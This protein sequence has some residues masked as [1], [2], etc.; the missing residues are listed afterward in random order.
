MIMKQIS[1]QL[2]SITKWKYYLSLIV[3]IL[4]SS[5]GN[6]FAQTSHDITYNLIFHDLY[7]NNLSERGIEII[8]QIEL[9]DWWSVRIITSMSSGKKVGVIVIGELHAAVVLPYELNDLLASLNTM[10][11]LVEE[12]KPKKELKNEAYLY[13]TKYTRTPF[14]VISSKAGRWK[15]HGP[16]E[17]IDSRLLGS[18]YSKLERAKKIFEDYEISNW[19]SDIDPNVTD[20][21]E[22]CQTLSKTL[23]RIES[24]MPVTRL[25]PSHHGPIV[26]N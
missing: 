2:V 1:L 11:S 10:M 26:P 4:F 22:L 20:V 24:F 7:G 23:Y 18:T 19:E 21:Y 13:V 6:V 17:I 15:D 9:D 14:G 5:T 3:C 8:E 16:D 25:L 12:K